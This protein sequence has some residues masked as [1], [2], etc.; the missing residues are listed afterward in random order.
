MPTQS[1]PAHVSLREVTADNIDDLLRLRVAETQRG[2]VADNAKSLA[3]AYVYPIAW[4]RAIYAGE[5]PV[6]FVMLEV[7]PADPEVF[8]WRLIVD[9]GEQGKGYGWAAMQLILAHVRT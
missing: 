2:F 8:L 9:A 4:P 6:G 1:D 5:T 3:Q 7:D